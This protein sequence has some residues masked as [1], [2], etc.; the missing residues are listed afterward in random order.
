M[1]QDARPAN[2]QNA[3]ETSPVSEE[4]SAR[5][6]LNDTELL[7]LPLTEAKRRAVAAFERHYLGCVMAQAGSVTK[8]ALAAGLDRTNFRRLLQRHGLRTR[9]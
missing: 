6:I 8:G 9:G 5:D 7:S 1:L 3:L 4:M 2:E